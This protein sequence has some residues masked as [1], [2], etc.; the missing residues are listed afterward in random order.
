MRFYWGLFFQTFDEF[1]QLLVP[2]AG[3]NAG[4]NFLAN[5]LQASYAAFRLT[6]QQ[7]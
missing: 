6:I 3:F 2:L 4:H 1:F 7:L 5:H